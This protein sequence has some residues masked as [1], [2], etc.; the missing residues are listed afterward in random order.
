MNF[1]EDQAVEVLTRTPGVVR[2]MLTNLCDHWLTAN[3]GEGTFSPFAVV[4]HLIHGERTDWV[5]RAKIILAH[6]E[7]RPFDAF[8]RYAMY[9]ASRGQSLDELLDTLERLRAEN[10]E[11]LATFDLSPQTLALRGTH[12]RLGPVTMAA[13]VKAPITRTAYVAR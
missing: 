10:L 11:T 8:D 12:P 2:A 3:Y 6:G 13:T 1:S 7:K 4:G 9:E 5:P